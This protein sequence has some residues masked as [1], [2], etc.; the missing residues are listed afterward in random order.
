MKDTQL[1]SSPPVTVV[2]PIVGLGASAGG[3]EAL[4]Q[5]LAEVSPGTGMAYVV[6]QH[7]DPEHRSMLA[8]LL[9]PRV[10]IPVV[11]VVDGMEAAPNRIHVIPPGAEIH[12]RDGVLSLV[13][14]SRTRGLHLPIDTFFRALAADQPGRGIGVVLSGSG[15]DGTDGLRAIKA[16]GGITLAQA[17]DSAQFRGMPASA[18]AAGVVDV[19]ASP[20]EL[21][22]ELVRLSQHPYLLQRDA[23]EG[24][25]DELG[26]VDDAGELAAAAIDQVRRHAGLDFRGYKRPTITRRIARRMVLRRVG[27]AKA[28]V[29]SLHDDPHEAIALGH[30][31]LVHVTSFFRDPAAFTALEQEVFPAIVRRKAD[32]EVIRVW[33]AGCST[34][35][36][37]Y[38]LAIGLCECL[39][40]EDRRLQVKLFATDLSERA[41]DV[42]RSGL[43]G[44]AELR[45][46]SPER[47]VRFFERVDGQHRICKRVR[48]MCVF[49]VHDLARQPPFAR[50]DLVSCRNLLI[51][52]DVELQRRVLPMLHNCL[53][54][55][56]YLLLGGSESIG[57][58]ID[59]F[60]P[61]D[62][63]RR[64]FLKTGEGRRLSYPLAFGRGA[65]PKNLA[66]AAPPA[67]QPMRDAQRQAERWLSSH[68]A[69]PGVLIDERLQVVQFHG[70]TGD[71]LEPPPGE[72]QT[73]VLRMARHGLAAHL[74]EAIEAAKAQPGVVRRPGLRLGE[75]AEARTIDLEVVPLA[76]APDDA[77]YFLLVFVG[78]PAPGAREGE[79]PR[80][81]SARTPSNQS[82]EGFARLAAELSVTQDYVRDLLGKHHET[83][84]ELASTNEEMVSA[85]EELQ[86]INEELESAK[87]EL[88]ATNE[89]LTT[90]N[91]ELRHRNRELDLV[92][93][94]LVNVLESVEIPVI[95]LDEDL[96][97]RRFTPR[98]REIAS[99]LPTDVGRSIDDVKLRIDM[100]DLTERIRKVIEANEP[101]EWEV[102]RLDGHWLRLQVR[103]YHTADGRLDGA[104]LAFVDVDG[105]KRALH[106]AELARD[107][108][109]DIV[110]TV[111]IALVVLDAGLRVVSTN[112]AF[113]QGLGVDGLVVEGAGLFEL[114][115]GAWDLPELRDAIERSLAANTRFREL[116]LRRPRSGMGE[117]VLLASGSPLRSSDGGAVMLVVLEDVTARRELEARER[118]ARL[119]AERSNL[120]K[121]LFLAT[122]SHELRTPLG[123]ILMAAQLLQT[124]QTDDPR[125][126]RASAAIQRAVGNQARLI[127]DLLD[128]SR[129]VS[130]KLMLDFQAVD[131]AAV[132]QAAVDVAQGSAEAKGLTLTLVAHGGPLGTIRGDPTRL[133]QLVAN[134]I[135]NAI[136]FTPSGGTITVELEPLDG[137]AQLVVRDTG[138]GVSPAAIP[139]LFDR[140]VQA[141]S[142]S[143]RVHGGLGL[144]LAIVRYLVEVH[145]GEVWAESA[146]EGQGSL[147]RVLLP[148][149]SELGV[150]P[151]AAVPPPPAGIVGVRVLMVEDDEGTRDTFAMMLGQ[152]GADVRVAASVAAGLVL[153]EQFRPQVILSDIAMPGE[154]GYGFIQRLRALGRE[155]GGATPAAALTALA[156]EEDRKRALEAGFQMHLAKPIDAGRL[157]AAVGMLARWPQ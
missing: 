127:D 3:L 149:A 78:R 102:Q 91:D 156:S 62:K 76:E 113:L 139:R 31:I 89:E 77:R 112:P 141:E 18:I 35:E 51:Y 153:V 132:A 25:I 128:I 82:D 11:E 21:G 69:P 36:E 23:S 64:I 79:G 90:V 40:R 10:Q 124:V 80:E 53:N 54:Q 118:G 123:T 96:R 155:R 71:F 63:E 138:C 135:G 33:I 16:A 130:G 97:V 39:D 75:G 1:Q 38:S 101:K 26:L 154:D 72:P 66:S 15:S 32:D 19:E 45:G 67:W 83:T 103:P 157:A 81:R 22:R 104:V 49:V 129:I 6:I 151:A 52:F 120:A 134:L 85:N 99:L 5:L 106:D 27:S 74:H 65:E 48:D 143:T 107:L 125:I 34:G 29:E 150:L 8:G 93:N 73:S 145:G 43:Y 148:L 115:D 140:F 109:R 144:G 131:L 60:V 100:T 14:R 55:P 111:P 24:D 70:R 47:L 58:F 9:A 57:G 126:A 88:Q 86:S 137:R 114:G 44:E 28:Y 41:I 56:G 50:I 105:L 17:P 37:A 42:A 95:I 119:E 46:V 136:K 30:D 92:A 142:S 117:Q 152:L 7:L 147:F 84:Q 98:V 20:A 4:Q 94:D 2:A 121:D 12:V 87:E 122:L 68:Y 133:Q 61:L 116:E 13:S 108:S 146:G 59:L 110:E